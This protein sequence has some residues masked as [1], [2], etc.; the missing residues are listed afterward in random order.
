MARFFV[1][2]VNHYSVTISEV[3]TPLKRY[4]WRG[5][6]DGVTVE[7]NVV[8]EPK[9]IVKRWFERGTSEIMYH[10][11]NLSKTGFVAWQANGKKPRQTSK[12]EAAIKA[13]MEKLL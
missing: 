9:G 2:S 3:F 11:R 1:V 13:K 5:S 12:K 6:I 10:A 8:K 7:Y 4:D